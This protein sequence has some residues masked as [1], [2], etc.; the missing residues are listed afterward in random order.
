MFVALLASLSGALFFAA[1]A[2]QAQVTDVVPS[3]G[4]PVVTETTPTPAESAPP[5]EP[6]A[7]PEYGAQTPGVE[8]TPVT[9]PTATDP[10]V[11]DPTYTVEPTPDAGPTTDPT[12]VPEPLP[13]PDPEPVPTP[14]PDPVVTDPAPEP[15]VPQPAPPPVSETPDPVPVVTDPVVTDPVV[16]DPVV[17][18]PAPSPE[19][20]PGAEPAP[21]V[22][23]VPVAE[24]PVP[25][26]A[27]QPAPA[28]EPGYEAVLETGTLAQPLSSA[29]NPEPEPDEPAPQRELPGAFGGME[30]LARL[31]TGVAS[32]PTVVPMPGLAEIEPPQ[33]GTRMSRREGS[34]SLAVGLLAATAGFLGADPQ[35]AADLIGQ[36]DDLAAGVVRAA[37]KALGGLAGDGEADD[38]VPAPPVPAFPPAPAPAPAPAPVCG[39]S[40]GSPHCNGQGDHVLLLAVLAAIPASSP[41]SGALRRRFRDGLLKPNS[42]LLPVAERPG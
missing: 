29:P 42:S 21:V 37:G 2:A 12:P 34:P 35:R 24:E 8:P 41:L 27:E 18:Q 26:V 38:P 25:V 6:S 7:S 33:T 9:D 19:P 32:E 23:P 30:P 22:E 40:G 16:T 13:T 39:S 31:M 15:T 4:D 28:P 10:T 17:A 1:G 3:S 36:L 20:A 5:P 14:E 11:T